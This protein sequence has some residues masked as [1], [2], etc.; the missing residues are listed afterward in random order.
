M[1]QSEQ[2]TAFNQWYTHL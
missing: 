2:K 1:E